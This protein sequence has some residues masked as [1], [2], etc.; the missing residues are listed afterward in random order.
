MV[1]MEAWGMGVGNGMTGG[2]IP[3]LAFYSL[4]F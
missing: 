4:I 1:E 2:R 3:G